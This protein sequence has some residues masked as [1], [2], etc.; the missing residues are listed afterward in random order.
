[1]P[2]SIGGKRSVANAAE[3][4]RKRD[5]RHSVPPKP[6]GGGLGAALA[7]GSMALRAGPA[8]PSGARHASSPPHLVEGEL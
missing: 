6:G 7:N 4:R 8:R 5:G 2:Q 3:H 1:M